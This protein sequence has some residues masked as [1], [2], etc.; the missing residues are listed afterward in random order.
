M[1]MLIYIIGPKDLS[2]RKEAFFKVGKSHTSA[3]KKRLQ[4]IQTG[5]PEELIVHS[6]FTVNCKSLESQCHTRL[7]STPG[8]TRENGEWFK[9]SF[10]QI[11]DVVQR[12]IELYDKNERYEESDYY[13]ELSEKYERSTKKVD[14]L[15]KNI[16]EHIS[17]LKLRIESL[18]STFDHY[19]NI[20][21]KNNELKEQVNKWKYKSGYEK[22][23]GDPF[24]DHYAFLDWT[25]L[26]K[27]LLEGRSHARHYRQRGDNHLPSFSSRY[28]YIE[29]IDIC[30]LGKNIFNEL[31]R[32]YI[33]KDKKRS[34]HYD[35]STTSNNW[36]SRSRKIKGCA[37]AETD[38]YANSKPELFVEELRE[39]KDE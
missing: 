4:S 26:I 25:F 18:R 3:L 9:G 17:E 14:K 23:Q 20:K 16:L 32:V 12:T 5:N 24:Y 38:I 31:W 29:R 21:K 35:R 11:R 2:G 6:D 28:D 1:S 10:S 22:Y 27:D 13:K 7:L 34:Q 8:I 37:I 36:G 19:K 39:D 33:D 15:E 30:V